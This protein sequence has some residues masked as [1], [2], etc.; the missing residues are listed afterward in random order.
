MTN[1]S[2]FCI[3][4]NEFSYKKKLGLIVLFVMNKNS[5]IDLYC[6]IWPLGL[7]INL[8]IESSRKSLLDLKEIT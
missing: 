6:A 2:I 8:R 1:T 4:V 7:V 3:I 5:E